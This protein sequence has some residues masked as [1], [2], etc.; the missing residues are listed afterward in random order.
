MP[1]VEN[2]RPELQGITNRLYFRRQF[3]LSNEA[4]DELYNWQYYNL[5]NSSH[6]YVHPDLELTVAKGGFAT[7]LL[8][9]N[10]FDPFSPEKTNQDIVSALGTV[11]SFN[12]LI[13][14]I[15]KYVGRYVIIYK[16]QTEFRIAHDAL[17]L[18]E[19]YYCTEFNRVIAGS[20][21]NLLDEFSEPKLGY[22]KDDDIS[23]FC[24]EDIGKVRSGRLWVGDETAY[25]SI[26]HLMPN[27][28]LDV[29]LLLPK[30]YWPNNNI[31]RIAIEAAVDRLCAYLKGA[32]LAM[33]LRHKIMMAVTSGIDSRSLLAA[34]RDICEGIYYFINK[35]PP[36]TDDSSDI[37]IP[38][39]ILSKLNIP[40]H[41]HDATGSVD[42]AFRNVFLQNTYMSSDLLL[43]AIYNVYYLK[44]HDKVNL[45]GVGEI[46]RE[47]YGAVPKV[48]TGYYLAHCLRYRQSEYATK[49]CELWLREV[50]HIT[51]EN[52]VDIMQLFLWEMLLG[53]WGSV[54]NSES[55]IAIEEFDP[56]D[57]HFVYETMLSVAPDHRKGSLPDLFRRIIEE[58]WPDLLD[59]PF[60]PA[61]GFLN[62]AVGW[63][64]Q[65][66]IYTQ[67][68]KA[69]FWID[70]ARY[71][72]RK[73]SWTSRETE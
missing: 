52:N 19:V 15:K 17:G 27:H 51:K 32:L 68:K 59:F 55:D 42:G 61:N 11:P 72:M 36:L 71:R 3:L 50:E 9:G 62:Q 48:L 24:T 63:L 5:D 31:E 45:L 4:V 28:Y 23:Y 29:Q 67:V 58:L 13:L 37:R 53:N 54:G 47:Y 39:A 41:I 16:S 6:L 69:R 22:T 2:A 34:S 33:A 14:T 21:P 7:V 38:R 12:E 64:D 57:S 56:Y 49:R 73:Y 66:G 20:Q 1:T 26:R 43:P 60:N 25:R 44:H 10:V 18:R 8:M 40:F 46:G 30:R 70:R 65:A 35:K